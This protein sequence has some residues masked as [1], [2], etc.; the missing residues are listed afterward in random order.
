MKFLNT[1]KKFLKKKFNL[2][3]K[4]FTETNFK[5]YVSLGVRKINDFHG[6]NF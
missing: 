1:F 2:K 3:K 6:L 4:F 5:K